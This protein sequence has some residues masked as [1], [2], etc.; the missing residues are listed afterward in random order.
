MGDFNVNLLN[1]NI[2]TIIK[3]SEIRCILIPCSHQLNSNLVNLTGNSKTLIDSIFF[4]KTLN[5]IIARYLCPLISD[6]VIQ[7]FIEFPTTTERPDH[8]KKQ[9]KMQQKLQQIKTEKKR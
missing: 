2:N 5:I 8:G 6:H 1:Y 3:I 9:G 7:Y 4:I